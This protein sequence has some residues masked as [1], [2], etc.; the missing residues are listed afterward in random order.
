M[1]GRS[2]LDESKAR[3]MQGAAPNE[4]PLKPAHSSLSEGGSKAWVEIEESLLLQIGRTLGLWMLRLVFAVLFFVGLTSAFVMMERQPTLSQAFG[5]T[6]MRL[7]A[8]ALPDALF[9][10]YRKWSNAEADSYSPSDVRFGYARDFAGGRLIV[11]EYTSSGRIEK[12]YPLASVEINPQQQGM[13]AQ[14]VRE[15]RGAEARFDI[16]INQDGVEHAVVWASGAPW[17]VQWISAGFA[18]PSPN[19]PSN[20]IDAAFAEYYWQ[21]FK[22]QRTVTAGD[23]P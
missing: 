17:N 19:P 7:R 16:Y 4:A 18:Y 1:P 22:G 9:W 8:K 12:A 14:W 11:H 21:Q 6:E 5:L 15:R 10:S 23:Q 13:I 2:E 20:V 3:A